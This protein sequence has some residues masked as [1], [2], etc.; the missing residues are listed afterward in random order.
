MGELPPELDLDVYR[1]ANPDLHDMS[2]WELEVHYR[3]FGLSEGR[4]AN[5]LTSRQQFADLAVQMGRSLEIGP[6]ASPLISGPQVEYAD[7]LSSDELRARAKEF[8]ISPSTVPNITWVVD[9]FELCSIEG[10]FDSVLSSHVVEHQPDLVSH[11]EQVAGLLKPGGRYFVLVP[12]HR[13]CFDHFI[14]PSTV[15]EVLSAWYEGRRK[16]CLRSVIEHRV[17]TTH[18]DATRHWAG[19]HG[20]LSAKRPE[21]LFGAMGEWTESEGGYIDVH[22]WYFTPHSFADIVDVLRACGL[23]SF[24]VDRI[25]STRRNALEFWA[26]LST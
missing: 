19:D 2:D 15:A 8:G 5:V 9:P 17:L 6:F 26:V 10:D 4:V 24:R 1:H 11:L 20:E 12:D 16:H 21:S 23:C 25:Y 7:I 3:R 13:Y 18:N 14:A 22:A